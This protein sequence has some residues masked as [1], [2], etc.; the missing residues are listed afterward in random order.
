MITLLLFVFIQKAPK[1]I[2]TIG[3]LPDGGWTI[4]C[5]ENA[6]LEL[7]NRYHPE[8]AVFICYSMS[9]EALIKKSNLQ[10]YQKELPS[11]EPAWIKKLTARKRKQKKWQPLADSPSDMQMD[12]DENANPRQPEVKNFSFSTSKPP[13]RPVCHTFPQHHQNNVKNTIG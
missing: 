11:K 8:R 12:L 13:M 7:Y 4:K 1:E 9:G 5:A 6:K 3:I 10:V 2:Q